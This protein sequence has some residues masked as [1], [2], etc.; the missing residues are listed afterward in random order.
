MMKMSDS[1]PI[2]NVRIFDPTGEGFTESEIPANLKELYSLLRGARKQ[3][4]NG[5]LEALSGCIATVIALKEFELLGG[6]DVKYNDADQRWDAK[7]VCVYSNDGERKELSP[8]LSIM[9]V[10]LAC[11]NNVIPDLDCM[12][13]SCAALAVG[14]RVGKYRPVTFTYKPQTEKTMDIT[15]AVV[16]VSPGIVAKYKGSYDI[17]SCTYRDLEEKVIDVDVSLLKLGGI[18][19]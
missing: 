2:S 15:R 11:A 16:L 17:E 1:S 19:S 14:D 4:D 9:V 18:V 6:F 3:K 12:K 10:C 7:L 8:A 13:D 5:L